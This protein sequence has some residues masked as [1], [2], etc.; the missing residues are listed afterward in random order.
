MRH[1]IES[2]ERKLDR[3]FARARAV[4]DDELRSDLARYGVVLVCGYVE[5]CVEVIMLERLSQK[6]HPRVIHFL[7]GH[8]KKGTNYDCEA[9]C[10][11]L[12]R[13]DQGW[14]S[15]FR[16]LINSNEE[17]ASSLSSAYSIR[18]SIAHGGDGNKGLAGVEAFYLD[19]KNIVNSLVKA[20]ER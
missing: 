5:R 4:N 8:F 20:T 6:A 3:F 16:D 2:R 10:Q 19:C 11:L 1:S 7:K 13:F 18:N 14:E 17:W 9:I 12:I 15:S